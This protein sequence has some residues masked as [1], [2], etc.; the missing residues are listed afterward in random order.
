MARTVFPRRRPL[1]LK[2]YDQLN[3]R[4]GA[5]HGRP[6]APETPAPPVPRPPARAPQPQSRLP[7]QS[8]PA[9]T[10]TPAPKAT[11]PTSLQPVHESLQS[12][13]YLFFHS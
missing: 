11:F 4:T 3:V 5:Q 8:K 7:H 10:S 6:P 1:L 9:S 12:M 2:N 13:R